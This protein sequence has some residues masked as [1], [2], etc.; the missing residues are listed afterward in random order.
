[1]RVFGLTGIDLPTQ[2]CALLN[3]Q[4]N[5]GDVDKS[6]CLAPS[7]LGCMRFACLNF[8]ASV[9]CNLGATPYPAGDTTSNLPHKT[10]RFRNI[11]VTDGP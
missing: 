6:E 11:S 2:A 8:V 1:M 3:K 4:G 10:S 5:Y 9:G 7:P